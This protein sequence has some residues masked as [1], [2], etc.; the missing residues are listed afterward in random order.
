[1]IIGPRPVVQ[2][3]HHCSNSLKAEQR[4]SCYT[5][6]C[7]VGIFDL[8][9][10]TFNILISLIAIFLINISSSDS[11]NFLIATSDPDSRFRHLNTTPYDPSPILLIF[12]YFSMS[13]ELFMKTVANHWLTGMTRLKRALN[14]CTRIYRLTIC[15]DSKS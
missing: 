7:S 11:I 8:G 3:K 12:S 14:I 4:R 15:N 6:T 2:N 1:V 13:W 10:Q 9:I 5:I